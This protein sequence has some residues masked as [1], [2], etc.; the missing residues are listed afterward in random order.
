M[1]TRPENTPIPND[2]RAMSVADLTAIVAQLQQQ[3]AAQ[4][5]QLAQRDHYI[6]LLEELL[7]LKQ[8]QKFAASSE[9]LAHQI[10]LFDEAELEAGIEALREQ[11][12]DGIEEQDAPR[13]RGTRRQRG[14][15]ASLT[16]ERIEL[17][18]SEETARIA[19]GAD[20]AG[21]DLADSEVHG[22]MIASQSCDILRSC[23]ERPYVEVCPL[24]PSPLS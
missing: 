24:V 3:L 23:A 5:A 4:Q 12:P 7:R 14:F 18:L 15:S 2:P 21:V 17:P 8:I 9:K 13:A 16:R 10:Q 19:A 1:Q 6:E 22:L 20:A 11:L